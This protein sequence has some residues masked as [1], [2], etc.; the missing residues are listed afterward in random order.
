MAALTAPYDGQ[1][2]DGEMTLYPINNNIEVFKGGMAALAASGFVQ[3]A[4]DAAGILFVGVFAES[5]SNLDGAIQPGQIQ[6][7]IG[8]P[9]QSFN[10]L[11]GQPI[12][13]AGALGAR[14]YKEGAF[15]FNKAAA[16]QTDLGKVALIV[17]DNT[18]SVAATTNNVPCGKIV[19]IID[20][21]HVR[22]RIDLEV[23]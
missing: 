2:K 4:A 3:P 10:T 23:N 11:N 1:R 5:V 9:G 12:G 18:V 17:D 8:S 7:S 6:Q 22:V 21:A 16:V 20:G 13:N 14:V 15:V 19:E